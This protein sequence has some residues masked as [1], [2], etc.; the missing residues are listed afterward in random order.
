MASTIELSPAETVEALDALDTRAR[1]SAEGGVGDADDQA[2]ALASRIREGQRPTGGVILELDGDEAQTLAAAAEV[3]A[4]RLTDDQADRADLCRVVRRKALTA[5]E[6][7]RAMIEDPSEGDRV[8]VEYRSHV[9]G[10]IVHRVGEVVGC[11]GD[12]LEIDT[13][14]E[15]YRTKAAL[16]FGY[17]GD[18]AKGV[19]LTTLRRRKGLE[20]R[21][22]HGADLNKRHRD[23]VT[24]EILERA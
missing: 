12:S 13:G 3:R 19:R 5:G 2:D 7:F 24:I 22:V 18:Q 15:D 9:S 6:G 16:W 17:E 23:E 11:V 21:W 4:H 1:G 8:R 14:R 20:P 10:T